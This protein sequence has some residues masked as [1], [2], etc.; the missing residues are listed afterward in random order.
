MNQLEHNL[1]QIGYNSLP[2]YKQV[3]I[4]FSMYKLFM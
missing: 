1:G 2:V 4:V 3:Q